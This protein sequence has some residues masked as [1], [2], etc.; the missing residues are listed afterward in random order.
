MFGFSL[1][2]LVVLVGVV[3]AVVYGAKLLNRFQELRDGEARRRRGGAR[4]AGHAQGAPATAIE[5]TVKCRICGAYVP[6][7]GAA[8]CGQADCPF[9]A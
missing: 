6:A 7:R 9:G 4:M 5:E 8:A 2:K 3:L 1:S